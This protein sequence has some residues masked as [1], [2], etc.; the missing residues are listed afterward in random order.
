MP[1]QLARLTAALAS[2]RQPESS[3]ENTVSVNLARCELPIRGAEL[4]WYACAELF[5]RTAVQNRRGLRVEDLALLAATLAYGK[6]MRELDRRL[7]AKKAFYLW[8]SCKQ[9]LVPSSKSFAGFAAFTKL[10]SKSERTLTSNRPNRFPVTLKK[11]LLVWMPQKRHPDRVNKFRHYL[12]NSFRLSVPSNYDFDGE[13]ASFVPCVRDDAECDQLT[14]KEMVRLNKVRLTAAEYD[15]HTLAF[16]RWLQ[17]DKA[18]KQSEKSSKG[19]KG[20]AAKKLLTGA[21][22]EKLHLG[23]R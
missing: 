14:D 21:D 23:K 18:R 17:M 9:R 4:L 1:L 2:N 11:A 20:R 5:K 7:A 6:P 13:N 10:I 12:R 3:I 15:V 22:G 19:G 16:F 8:Q